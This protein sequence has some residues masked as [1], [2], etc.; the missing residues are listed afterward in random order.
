M[1]EQKMLT[2]KDVM[3]RLG[4][5]RTT[6]LNLIRAG[7]I[8]VVRVTPRCLRVPESAI[9]QFVA[10]RSTGNAVAS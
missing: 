8:S 3:R 2:T 1:D 4:V 7:K 10:A 9:E 6:A 5:S